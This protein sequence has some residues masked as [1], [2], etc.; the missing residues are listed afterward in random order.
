[1]IK[2]IKMPSSKDKKKD[3]NESVQDTLQTG[4]TSSAAAQT[5]STSS[6][7]NPGTGTGAEGAGGGMESLID[8]LVIGPALSCHTLMKRTL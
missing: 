2:S 8:K 5:G 7:T 6:M 4:S 1:M 3:S